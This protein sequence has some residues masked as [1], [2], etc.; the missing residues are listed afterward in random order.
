MSSCLVVGCPSTSGRQG[1]APAP[2]RQPLT[3]RG[4][5][6]GP[7]RYDVEG[8]K[9]FHS[10]PHKWGLPPA[11]S[12]RA[13]VDAYSEQVDAILASLQLE[14]ADAPAPLQ[15]HPPQPRRQQRPARARRAVPSSSESSESSGSSESEEELTVVDCRGTM[16]L[17]LRRQRAGVPAGAVA[18]CAG[19]DCS[20]RGAAAVLASASAAAQGSRVAVAP[21]KCLG[22]C[23]RGPN[24]KVTV[25]GGQAVV[26][27]GTDAGTAAQVM[28]LEFGLVAQAELHEFAP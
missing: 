8:L 13:R 16:P 15:L 24:V 2:A 6:R 19:K 3:R 21:C 28:A 18:V 17:A 27:T 9:Y 12:S 22:M 11:S 20:R 10:S 4:P 1:F 23:G 14:G 7:A 5:V 25:P 26:Y